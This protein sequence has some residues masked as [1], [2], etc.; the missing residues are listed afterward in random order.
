MFKITVQCSAVNWATLSP[1]LVTVI[2][3]RCYLENHESDF[4]GFSGLQPLLAVRGE[5]LFVF[6]LNFT[7]CAWT[8]TR[9][10]QSITV[11]VVDWQD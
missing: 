7:R 5:A 8:S 9:S 3:F 6:I 4:S 1:T 11:L 2:C 10:K